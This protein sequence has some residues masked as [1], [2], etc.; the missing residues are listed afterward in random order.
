MRIPNCVMIGLAVIVGETIALGKVPP[1]I[2]SVAGFLTASLMMGGTMALN[3]IYDLE[4]DKL[5][6]PS[7]P[8]VSGRIG[9]G[10]AKTMSALLS[11]LSI[12][13]AAVIGLWT[14]LIA[15][16][17][18]A[19]MVYYNTRGKR[20]GLL[21]NIVV[22]FN[23]ALP[24]F[25]GGIAVN[26]LRPLLFVFSVLA[27][28]ANLGREVAKGIPDI[29]GDKASGVRTIAVLR[30]PKAAA[31]VSSGLFLL[32]VLLSFIPLALG[33]LSLLY[34]PGVVLADLGFVYS[35]SRLLA[36]QDPHSVKKVKSQV[37]LWMLF[38]LIGFLLG[39]GVAV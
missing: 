6:S 21:G 19:L 32:A 24:F 35:S 30:G 1:I 22:S 17:A 33:N 18:L 25:Y 15:L 4:T 37:L 20:T 12:V 14:T 2:N 16:L 38:G 3:D 7:R 28:L 23:V 13:F 9:L 11:I 34:F 31:W 26:S 5:N 29:Q 8:L 10:G 27:F 36:N 39:G